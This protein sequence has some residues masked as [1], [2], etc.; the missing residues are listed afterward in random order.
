MNLGEKCMKN[1]LILLAS[2]LSL[3][4]F[5]SSQ[6]IARAANLKS[7][8]DLEKNLEENGYELHS[9][10]DLEAGSGL[11]N[12]CGCSTYEVKFKKSVY[13]Q[14][15]QKWTTSSKIYRVETSMTG[16]EIV[17]PLDQSESN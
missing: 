6:G 14:A 9:I 15:D 13:T 3:S 7:V 17:T 10:R 5:A 2:V 1:L 11:H 8:T 4:A 16:N 12:K